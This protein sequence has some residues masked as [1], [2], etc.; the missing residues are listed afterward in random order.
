M[1]K[2]QG[3]ILIADPGPLYAPHDTITERDT[4]TC[5]HCQQVQEIKPGSGA[6]V[7]L[8]PDV[9]PPHHYHEEMGAFCRVCMRPICLRCHGL[10]RCVPWERMLE[11][12]EHRHGWW[13]RFLALGGI[14]G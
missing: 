7:Y 11:Q 13:R 12:M 2:P 6:T 1:L 10:G 4:I 5:G 8:I 14:G 9:L 3:Y